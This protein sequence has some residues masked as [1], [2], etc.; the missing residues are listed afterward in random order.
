LV[1]LTPWPRV[2]FP[3]L[4]CYQHPVESQLKHLA[5]RRCFVL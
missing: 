5:A 1:K 2:D 3:V 4:A